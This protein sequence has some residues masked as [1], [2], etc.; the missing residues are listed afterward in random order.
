[1][2]NTFNVTHKNSA[3]AVAIF[4]IIV[5]AIALIA[6]CGD[7]DTPTGGNPPVVSGD[8]LLFSLDSFGIVTPPFTKDTSIV[9]SNTAKIKIIFTAET[10]ADSIN[11]WS[12]F[13]VTAIDTILNQTVY[14]STYNHTLNMNN[15]FD[16]RINNIMNATAITFRIQCLR[17]APHIFFMKLKNIK[18][19]KIN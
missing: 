1:M 4:F 8:S 11:G 16:L 9:I 6:G 12:L 7:S 3:K 18:V 15:A 10:N 19:F 17:N 5:V 2:Q 14:D 13:T